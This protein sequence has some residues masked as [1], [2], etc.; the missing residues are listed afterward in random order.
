MRA[1]NA[2]NNNFLLLTVREFG[3]V[4]IRTSRFIAGQSEAIKMM[5]FNGLIFLDSYSFVPMSLDKAVKELTL[6]GHDFR[7]LEESK[8][9]SSPS[10]RELLLQK[11]WVLSSLLL[12]RR[13][14]L[15]SCF[16]YYFYEAYQ[17]FEELKRQKTIPPREK[18][19]SSLTK[20]SI[21]NEAYSHVQ[22]VWH[23]FRMKDLSQ[24]L[25]LY[26]QTDVVLLAEVMLAFRREMVS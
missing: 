9:Y 3:A 24:Y 4:G 21:D 19:Y 25:A 1:L 17:T 6:S 5:A 15:F 2:N 16:S 10:Q 22:R 26:T 23:S 11:G 12:L 20:K 13:W 8:L 7:I 14:H 18:F